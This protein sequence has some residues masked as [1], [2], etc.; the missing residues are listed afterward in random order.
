MDTLTPTQYNLIVDI[1]EECPEIGGKAVYQ[2]RVLRAMEDGYLRYYPDTCALIPD[3][4]SRKGIHPQAEAEVPY[5]FRLYPNP[6]DN[7]LVVDYEVPKGMAVTLEIRD[8]VG[9]PVAAYDLE[10]D[11]RQLR[12]DTSSLTQ[13]VYFCRFRHQER[14][15]DVMKLLIN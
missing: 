8:V 5:H 4:V 14:I 9:R 10:P 12:I 1:A 11:N 3:S 6:A 2:A 7:I 15:L 13:G